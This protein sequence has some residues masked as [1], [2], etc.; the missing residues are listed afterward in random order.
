MRRLIQFLLV[1]YVLMFAGLH[2]ST[3]QEFMGLK[4]TNRVICYAHT[5]DNPCY[6]PPPEEFLAF[7]NGARKKTSSIEVTYNP[8]FTPEA[9]AAFNYA[10][11]IWESLIVSP[12]PIRIDAYWSPL[13]ASTLGSALYTSAYVNFRNAPKLNV[14]YPVALAEKMIG[15]NLNGTEPDLFIQFNSNIDWHYNPASSPGSGKYDLVSVVLHEI[16]HGLGFAGTFSSNGTTGSVGLQSTGIPII[17]D[18]P[19]ENGNGAN[20]IRSNPSPSVALHTDLTGNNLFFNSPTSFTPKLFAPQS[21]STGSSISH[22]DEST[23]NN[24]NDALMTPQIAPSEKIHNPGVA[25]NMLQD[26]GWEFVRIV[27]QP[28][29]DRENVSNPFVVTTQIQDDNGF[30][31]GSVTLFYTTNGTT[32]TGVNMTPT[33]NPK[34]FS[35]SIPATGTPQEYGY[36]ITVR[37]SKNREFTNPGKIVRINNTEIQN[38]FFFETGPD[39]TSPTIS[40]S[41]KLFLLDS[42]TSLVLEARVTDNIGIASVTVEYAINGITQTPQPL[43]LSSPGEDSIYTV[44]LNIGTRANGDEITYRLKAIDNSLNA[45]QAFSPASGFYTL[46]VVG[47]EPT[48]DSYANDFNTPSSDFFGNGFS[49]TQPTGFSNPAIHTTHP[50]PEGIGFPNDQLTFIYQLKIPIRISDKDATMRFDEIVLVEPGEPGTVFGDAEFWDYVIVEGSKDGGI[51]WTPVLNGY[52]SRANSAWVTR[53]NSASSGNNST[54]IGDPSLFRPRTIDLKNTFTPGDEVVIRFRLFS[55]P[56]AAGWG[57]AIDNLKIQIDDVPPL[58]LHDHID[59]LK[60]N[61]DELSILTKVSD[62]S[63]IESL[64]IEYRINNGSLTVQTFNVNPPAASYTFLLTGLSALAVGDLVEYKIVATDSAGNE[65]I[66]PPV[67]DFVKVPIISFSA[68]VITY[69]NSFNTPTTDFVGNFFSVTQPA[70]FTDGA[71]HSAHFYPNGVG[72]NRTSS[73]RYTLKKPVTL[74]A[75]NSYIRFDEIV[76]VEGHPSGIS[77]GS[78]SF[79]DYV[80]VEGSKDGGNTWNRFIDGYDLVGGESSWNTAFNS[81]DNGNAS[82]FRRR[83][84]DLTA[85]SSFQAGDQVLIRFRLFSDETING[86]GW[87]IDNLF[88]QDPITSAEQALTNNLKI[89]P[90]PIS[91]ERLTIELENSTSTHLIEMMTLQGQKIHSAQVIPIDGTLLHQIDVSGLPHGMYLIILQSAGGE[92][93]IRKIIKTN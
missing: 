36:Y 91:N 29:P 34:E 2:G 43:T 67:G 45:N 93:V 19:A 85:S 53:Y 69:A 66:F 90:N 12:V 68:P 44:S 6:I 48:Q 65:G 3:A 23:F 62:N 9:E 10:L 46:N 74:S 50:Y 7:K 35:G 39:L 26:M 42:E 88:I 5:K 61:D 80:I 27:H 78:A 76:I 89:Y 92:K 1:S 17:Y 22:L 18:V 57:W 87:A 84:F 37:D 52:D 28:L 14:F 59:Y 77:F 75:T 49:I 41:P 72:L 30:N 31:A 20:L 21:F 60:D 70:G 32:F 47:L 11:E 73:F 81:R 54:A 82:M 58:V 55:D 51:T 83:A 79:K 8:G 56:L 86:W 40:H 33:G 4:T 16:A 15:R 24:T 63:G 64:R 38:L 71:I 25:L 13:G